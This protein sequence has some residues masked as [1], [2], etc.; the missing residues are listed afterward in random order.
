MRLQHP[1]WLLGIV[2]IF[3][4]LAIALMFIRGDQLRTQTLVPSLPASTEEFSPQGE[5]GSDYVKVTF[6]RGIAANNEPPLMLKS[7]DVT[8]RPKYDPNQWTRCLDAFGDP[9]GNFNDA[10]DSQG[11]VGCPYSYNLSSWRSIRDGTATYAATHRDGQAYPVVIGLNYQ[12]RGGM[13]GGDGISRTYSTR[14]W[15]NARIDIQGDNNVLEFMIQVWDRLAPSGGGGRVLTLS[16]TVDLLDAREEAVN[17]NTLVVY[18][19][20]RVNARYQDI[21]EAPRPW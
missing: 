13:S 17:R 14:L 16:G 3:V 8:V 19:P 15:T 18:R 6:Q 21:S 11:T 1:Y 10:E 2:G 5:A 7:L 4:V 9:L 12:V 20:L